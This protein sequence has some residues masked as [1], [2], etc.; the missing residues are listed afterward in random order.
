MS[1]ASALEKNSKRELKLISDEA[2][3][4]MKL[5]NSRDEEI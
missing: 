1:P 3:H 4:Y 2:D 5:L